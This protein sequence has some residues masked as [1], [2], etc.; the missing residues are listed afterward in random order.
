[1]A[2]NASGR[3]GDELPDGRTCVKTSPSGAPVRKPAGDSLLCFLLRNFCL[4]QE[5]CTF[6]EQ[7][8]AALASIDRQPRSRACGSLAS[9]DTLRMAAFEYRVLDEVER[10]GVEQMYSSSAPSVY[11]SPFR[12]HDRDAAACAKRC[13][14]RDDA[15]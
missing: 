12:R 13:P 8:I 15:G 2:H 10:L 9:F 5:G 7:S 14:C 1:M 6:Q 4:V 11:A 3:P